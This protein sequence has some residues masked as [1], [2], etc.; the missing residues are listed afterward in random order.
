MG[1]WSVGV[2]YASQTNEAPGV[3]DFDM[4]TWVIGGTYVLGPGITAFGGLQIDDNDLAAS[5]A[6]RMAGKTNTFFIGTAL[7]F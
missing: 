6:T 1:P 2:Q 4:D 3:A 5:T 7:S